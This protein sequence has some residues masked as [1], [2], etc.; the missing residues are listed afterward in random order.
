MLGTGEDYKRNDVTSGRGCLLVY[1][2]VEMCPL[3]FSRHEHGQ[4]S[5]PGVMTWDLYARYVGDGLE[6]HSSR[7][8]LSCTMMVLS[9]CA[10]H[11]C[12]DSDGP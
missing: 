11:Q 8:L 9:G 10:R 4:V 1:G 2:M 3:S 7:H 5:A 6:I 12:F